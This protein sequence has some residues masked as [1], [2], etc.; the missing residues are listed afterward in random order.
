[1]DKVGLR[2][3]HPNA[4]ELTGSW[5]LEVKTKKSTLTI[6][7]MAR[8]RTGQNRCGV[9]RGTWWWGR[10]LKDG[11]NTA[12]LPLCPTLTEMKKRAE[13]TRDWERVEMDGHGR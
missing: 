11:T 10:E 12:A 8:S 13:K 7:R 5:L 3:A 2:G 6:Q 4:R 9:E 1:M